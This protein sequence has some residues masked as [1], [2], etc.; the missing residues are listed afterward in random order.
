MALKLQT[1]PSGACITLA[2]AKLHLRVDAA[3][4]DALITAL[5]DAAT[6]DAEHLM[7]RA[8]MPQQWKLTVDS[9]TSDSVSVTTDYAVSQVLGGGVA[10][11]GGCLLLQRPT[12]ISV[13]SVKYIA[14]ATGVQTTLANTE[15]QVDLGNDLVG[16]LA[17]AYGKSWPS[18][19]AQLG[20]V[21]V[22]FTC[23][24]ADAAAVPA[25]VKQWIK[26]RIGALYENRE[27]WTFH[28]PIERNAFVDYL[29]D[30]YRVFTI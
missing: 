16:R 28:R 24:W 5:I 4:E 26:L 14:A 3:D 11:V 21:E 12:V 27:A 23:G 30:R 17:P 6:Q 25:V 1:A 29:L 8:V 15:Y 18:V 9:F 22:L 20:A 10:V 2:E 7:Q 19:R 13:D